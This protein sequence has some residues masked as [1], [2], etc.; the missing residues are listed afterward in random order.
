[1]TLNAILALEGHCRQVGG[2]VK[3]CP[4]LGAGNRAIDGYGNLVN[5]IVPEPL[6]NFQPKLAL[7]LPVIGPR[8][9]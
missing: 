3:K 8:T 4:V 1:M 2:T 5:A 7:I 6:K 9:D